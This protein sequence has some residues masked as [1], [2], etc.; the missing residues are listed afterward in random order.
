MKKIL[1]AFLLVTF[2]ATASFGAPLGAGS[3]AVPSSESGRSVFPNL[4]NQPTVPST[5]AVGKL[6]TGVY[7]SWLTSKTAYALQTQHASGVRVFGSAADSTAIMWKQLTT[8]QKGQNNPEPGATD[9]ATAFA[10]GSGGW[11]IM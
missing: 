1:A 11:S 8:A 4:L 3:G 2:A 9:A 7:I 6:S 5:V 10:T